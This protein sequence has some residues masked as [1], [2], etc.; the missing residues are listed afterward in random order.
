MTSEIKKEYYN[1]GELQCIIPYKDGKRHGIYRF[2]DKKGR[3]ENEIH[4]KDDKKHG[5]ERVRKGGDKYLTLHWENG[6]IKE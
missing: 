5:I 2:Y 1:S 3:I 6:K 4:Y